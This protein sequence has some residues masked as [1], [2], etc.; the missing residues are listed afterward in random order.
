LGNKPLTP[1]SGEEENSRRDSHDDSEW[2]DSFRQSYQQLGEA[3]LLN[4]VE[5]IR[6]VWK[7]LRNKS[8]T[9]LGDFE[10]LINALTKELTHSKTEYEG[11]EAALKK[12][13]SEHEEEVRHLYEEMETQIK[14]ERERL[15]LQTQKKLEQ[16]EISYNEAAQKKEDLDNERIILERRLEETELNLKDCQ[17]YIEVL[18]KKARDERRSRARAAMELSEGIAL[19]RETLVRQLNELRE[20][21]RRLRDERDEGLLRRS[22]FNQ[23]SNS[24][25]ESLY[26]AMQLVSQGQTT[27]DGYGRMTAVCPNLVDRPD[28][29]AAN[30][31]HGRR[32]STMDTY[33]S[34]IPTGALCSTGEGSII[35]EEEAG[36]EFTDDVSDSVFSSR[37]KRSH[38]GNSARNLTDRSPRP[39]PDGAI[40][41]A[42]IMEDAFSG[43]GPE[44]V[45]KV[46]SIGNSGVGKTSILQMFV[47]GTFSQSAT[48]IGVD[49][50]V[51][52]MKVDG[53]SVVLQLW[54]TA[55][56][57]RYRSITTQY[58]RKADGVVLVYDLTSEMSF[59]QLRGWMQNVADGV[60]PG[61]PV[62]LLAN[63]ADL[64]N[65][66]VPANV[67]FQA[68]ERFAK[69]RNVLSS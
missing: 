11:L 13:I 52:P 33:F 43:S 38:L 25:G 8:P 22:S 53:T 23:R 47:T 58:F 30:V 35:E 9:L 7:K 40:D 54:D 37:R 6:N 61:T 44:R 51:K 18:S 42:T 68:G 10:K 56:Q 27:V 3:G 36:D 39:S 17:E 64:L 62:M 60:D 69:V 41:Q 14:Q 34:Q 63:K 1:D 5:S 28:R 16:L 21:N 48:T 66:N 57:E 55:G 15:L 32:G 24:T 26:A 67:T 59:L 65:E 19:E 2:E 31:H 45:F 49:V 12:R 46:I 50:Q 4:D 29:F 20:T